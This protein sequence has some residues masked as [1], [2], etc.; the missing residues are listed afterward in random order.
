MN[1][2]FQV[3]DDHLLRYFHKASALV[4]DF[5]KIEIMHI[6]REDNS[7][8]DMFSKFSSGKEKGQL[9]TIIDRY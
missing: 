8:V 7:W 1:G 9:T 5:D 3:K 6:P 2:D 4:K